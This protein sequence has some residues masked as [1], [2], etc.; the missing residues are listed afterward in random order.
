MNTLDLSE[1]M[2]WTER[3]LGAGLFIQSVELIK[4]RSIYE[5]G[6]A[7]E[8]SAVTPWLAL[9]LGLASLLIVS[10]LEPLSWASVIANMLLLGN[11]IWL[12]V[13]S[14]G[15]VCGGSDSMLFQVQL[16]LLIGSLGFLEPTLVKLGLGWIAAQSVLSYFLAGVSKLR[17][18]DWWNGR[19]LQNLLASKGPYVVFAPA[20]RLASHRPLCGVLGGGMIL[21]ELLFPAVLILPM[22]GK[23]ALLS[24]G[25]LFHLG[26]ALLLGLNRFLWAWAATYPAILAMSR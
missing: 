24:L 10:P 23:I 20:R 15:P 26:N 5:S 11:S 22:E 9:R 18:D 12:T 14:R 6:G 13:R 7:L 1:A 2:L 19:A 16:G 3:L 21:F 4:T 17:T 25:L 8:G